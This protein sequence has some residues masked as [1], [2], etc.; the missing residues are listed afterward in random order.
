MNE[1]TN[2]VASPERKHPVASLYIV[3]PVIFM[4]AGLVLSYVVFGFF[5]HC[6]DNLMGGQ[7]GFSDIGSIAGAFVLMAAFTYWFKAEF[8]GFYRKVEFQDRQLLTILIMALIIDLLY[9]VIGAGGITHFKIP[10]IAA[11]LSELAAGIC[12]EATMRAMP[13]SVAM[14]RGSEKKNIII[15]AVVSAVPFGLIHFLNIFT[16]D[17]DLLYTLV[18][19]LIAVAVGCLYA[20]IYLRTGNILVTMILHAFHDLMG[21]CIR[22]YELSAAS[23]QAGRVLDQME[24]YLAAFYGVACLVLGILL[25]VGHEKKIKEVWDERWSRT[26]E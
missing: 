24:V 21:A 12:E 4:V 5:G 8:R 16:V 15:A 23:E 3:G 26:L 9:T 14:R 17:R 10:A 25:I 6:I 19:V 11:I 7:Y 2:K 20:G 13:I 1:N 18:Q 22:A